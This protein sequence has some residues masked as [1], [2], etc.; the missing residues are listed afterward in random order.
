MRT[1]RNS[2]FLAFARSLE[3]IMQMSLRSSSGRRDL[4]FVVFACAPVNVAK[5]FSVAVSLVLLVLDDS[6][7]RICKTAKT[8]SVE[9][10]S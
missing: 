1:T 5:V 7:A 4:S 8:V 6:F 10:K 2:V 9:W 3:I